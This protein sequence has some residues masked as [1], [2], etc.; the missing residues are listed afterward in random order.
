M[1]E[2]QIITAAEVV[3][4]VVFN[5]I[6][7]RFCSPLLKNNYYGIRYELGPNSQRKRAPNITQILILDFKAL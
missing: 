7:Q 3:V 2:R 4:V 5:I 1:N 6:N